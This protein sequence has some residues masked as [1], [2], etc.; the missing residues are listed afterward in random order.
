MGST[1]DV[2]LVTA[3]LDMAVEGRGPAP[4]CT[5]HSDRGSQ[6]ACVQFRAALKAKGFL[7]SRVSAA[8]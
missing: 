5:F 1:M 4:G 8:L 2:S 7:P 3:A 6:Y